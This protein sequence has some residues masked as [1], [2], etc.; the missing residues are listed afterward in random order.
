M[1]H[2]LSQCILWTLRF[3]CICFEILSMTMTIIDLK[4][5]NCSNNINWV[6]SYKHKSTGRREEKKDYGERRVGLFI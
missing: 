5:E 3:N 2:V 6:L 4:R 1:T